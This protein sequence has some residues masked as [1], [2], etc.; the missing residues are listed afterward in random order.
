[1]MSHFDVTVTYIYTFVLGESLE[2]I[3]S[4]VKYTD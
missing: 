2:I 3:Y 1:M 4:Y